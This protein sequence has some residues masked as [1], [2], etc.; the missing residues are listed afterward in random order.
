MHETG[1]MLRSNQQLLKVPEIAKLSDQLEKRP[2]PV[3]QTPL[4]KQ[5][6]MLQVLAG[7]SQTIPAKFKTKVVLRREMSGRH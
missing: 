7:F 2:L 5:I 1:S 4:G 6:E 3:I